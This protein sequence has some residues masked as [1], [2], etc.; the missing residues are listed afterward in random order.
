MTPPRPRQSLTHSLRPPG[1]IPP[2][3]QEVHGGGEGGGGLGKLLDPAL[4]RA[5]RQLPALFKLLE[6]FLRARTCLS[7][8][9]PPPRKA[10]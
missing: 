10:G 1:Q 2:P 5:S 7:L 3:S 4:P 9:P 6:M 8:Q